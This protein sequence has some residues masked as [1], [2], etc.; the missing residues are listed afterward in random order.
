MGCESVGH[1]VSPDVLDL[2]V[3][4]ADRHHDQ[5]ALPLLLCEPDHARTNDALRTST[6]EIAATGDVELALEDS[7]ERA[8]RGIDGKRRLY[9]VR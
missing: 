4:R 5:H 7:G 1:D 2:L 9:A 6:G 8:L 3:G